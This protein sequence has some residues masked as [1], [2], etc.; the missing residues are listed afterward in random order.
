MFTC[1]RLFVISVLVVVAF[2]YVF[3]FVVLDDDR[4]VLHPI[5]FDSS[6]KAD[7]F[8]L[9]EL[10]L[11]IEGDLTPHLDNRSIETTLGVQLE[12]PSRLLLVSQLS[13]VNRTVYVRE[14]STFDLPR[15]VSS[16][17][18]VRLDAKRIFFLADRRKELL[19]VNV[20]NNDRLVLERP[21]SSLRD[22]SPLVNN[23]ELFLV[24]SLK[25]LS[26]FHC[27]LRER[28]CRRVTG[29]GVFRDT[30]LFLHPAS[31]FVQ[32]GRGT[33]YFV[34]FARSCSSTFSRFHLVVLSTSRKRFRL[35]YVSDA[36]VFE[37]FL[38]FFDR[39]TI[40][41]IR[42][43]SI[44]NSTNDQ[45]TFTVTVD[46]HKSYLIKIQGV[47][48]LRRSIVEQQKN[49]PVDAIQSIQ[50]VS[51]AEHNAVKYCQTILQ[52]KQ[53]NNNV[54]DSQRTLIKDLI[55]SP[56]LPSFRLAS[57][58]EGKNLHQWIDADRIL[59]GLIGRFLRDYELVYPQSRPGMNMMIDAG[60][61]HGTY[62]FYAATLNQSVQ[63][64][65][66]LPK[67]CFIIEESIRINSQWNRTILFHR[68]GVSDR[69]GTWRILPD[70][71]TTR[72]DY[73]PS[74]N[75]TDLFATI[76]TAPLDE[77]IFQRVSLLK[78]DVEGFEIRALQGA[79][80]ALQFFG[81]GAILIEIAPARWIW[82]NIT[83][84]QG[85]SELNNITRIGQFSTYLIA[86]NDAACSN[87]IF[88]T[89]E[90]FVERRNLSMLSMSTG[91]LVFAPQ[92][93]QFFNWTSVIRTMNEKRWDCNFWLESDL[94]RR[95]V[96]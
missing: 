83:V 47:D 25:P 53:N 63:I 23:G 76:R 68:F 4:V 40:R 84:E 31:E 81:V 78:I 10:R 16:S 46:R 8:D 11:T 42:P 28:R 7:S 32:F 88:S 87:E 29:D 2:L 13:D 85:I 49:K 34:G 72:L 59:F 38:P 18:I 44:V 75:G 26:V 82:N 93:Y 43:G 70:D 5:G 20:F 24:D 90:G 52:R 94:R 79:H 55:D 69:F 65:E 60:G 66:V 15:D 58:T 1:K 48:R 35:V 89:F 92:V 36:F 86:R 12:S 62:A 96:F 14:H 3:V 51:A 61:N 73:L 80:R 27:S 9:D 50:L 6:N 39:P 21:S 45:F 17:R 54:T 56:T 74:T 77:F 37:R 30:S 33:D 19:L 41:T 67:Y 71:G 95:N 64:F 91:Q 22:S 57:T